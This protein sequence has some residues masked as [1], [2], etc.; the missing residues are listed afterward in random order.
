MFRVPKNLLYIA[1]EIQKALKSKAPL[2]ALEST[3]ITHGMPYP[4]NIQ[5]ALAVEDIIREQVKDKNI[6]FYCDRKRPEN[7]GILTKYALNDNYCL[8]VEPKFSLNKDIIAI[9]LKP[10]YMFLYI[11]LARVAVF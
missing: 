8:N 7:E 10:T 3:I 1:P 11:Q 6:W 4:Q 5:T 9:T 2:V